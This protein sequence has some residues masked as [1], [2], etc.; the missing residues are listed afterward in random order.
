[1][2]SWLAFDT[3]R[4]MGFGH[5]IVN[6]EHAQILERGVNLLTVDGTGRVLISRY[7]SGLFELQPRYIVEGGPP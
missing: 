5:A 2:E 7:F 3:I 1:M 6:R 4:R